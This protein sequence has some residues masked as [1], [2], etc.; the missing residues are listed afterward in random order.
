[1]DIFA[2]NRLKLSGNLVDQS[3]V[4]LGSGAGPKVD[5]VCR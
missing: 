3:T 1:M 5:N 4:R 2:Q